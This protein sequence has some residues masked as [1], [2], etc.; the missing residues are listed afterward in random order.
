MTLATW[1]CWVILLSAGLTAVVAVLGLV[2][3]SYRET[4]LENMALCAVAL[5][6]AVVVLQI[7]TFGTAQGSGVAF[8]SAA[9]A[10][11]A[12]AKLL[13]ARTECHP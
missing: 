2:S 12:V 4:L 6:G 13:K 11:Y 8:L 10:A 7:K 1:Y 9:V 3:D 5:A